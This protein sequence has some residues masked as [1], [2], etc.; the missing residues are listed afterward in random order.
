[1]EKIYKVYIEF[2]GSIKISDKSPASIFGHFHFS[3]FINS[4]LNQS[5]LIFLLHH[6]LLFLPGLLNFED[7]KIS[8]LH[9]QS[10]INQ[11]LYLLYKKSS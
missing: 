1:M 8:F 5:S 7:I 10:K 6:F 2:S 9:W 3:L 11:H 4:T